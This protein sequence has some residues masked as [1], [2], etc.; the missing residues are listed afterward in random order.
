MNPNQTKIKRLFLSF[1]IAIFFFGIFTFSFAQDKSLEVEYPEILGYKP[2]TVTSSLPEYVNYI[3]NFAVWAGGLTAFGV[4]VWAGIRYLTSTGS[5]EP[6]RDAK[7]QFQAALLGLAI[8]FSSYLILT[9]INPQLVILGTKMPTAIEAPPFSSMIT[10]DY[11]D[12]LVRIK[13]LTKVIEGVSLELKKEAET[14][15]AKIENCECENCDSA[16]YC[17]GLSCRAELCFGDPCNNQTQIRIDLNGEEIIIERGE[18]R[19]EIKLSQVET[20]AKADEILYY[21]NRVD[22]EREDLEPE[23]EQFEYWGQLTQNQSDQ[24]MEKLGDLISPLRNIANSSNH[25]VDLGSD[26]SPGPC[27]PAGREKTCH[28]DCDWCGGCNNVTGCYPPSCSGG[29]DCC[30]LES[31]EN[32]IQRI[33]DLCQEISQI[34][35]DIISILE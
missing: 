20:I 24:L 3:F 13:E 35:Q 32:E 33:N 15:A 10:T 25:L 23:L 29:H 34:T 5:P 4:L 9:T 18:L 16:C 12:P 28:H 6:R 19:E 22:S 11:P 21:K 26:C 27:E 1:L 2:E 7:K 14:L 8:L 31:I 30:P 17:L